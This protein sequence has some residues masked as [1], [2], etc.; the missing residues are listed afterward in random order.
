MTVISIHQVNS[1]QQLRGQPFDPD[2]TT[3]A[4]ARW[5]HSAPFDVKHRYICTDRRKPGTGVWP[6]KDPRFEAWLSTIGS[7]LLL[8]KQP[9]YNSQFLFSFL[10]DNVRGKWKNSCDVRCPT[11]SLIAFNNL[12]RSMVIDAI[13][14]QIAAD[15]AFTYFYVDCSEAKTRQ[16][17]YILRSLLAQFISHEPEIIQAEFRDLM[18]E[19]QKRVAF[20]CFGAF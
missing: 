15:H 20:R 4:M 9:R 17:K 3:A 14:L 11:Y 1:H 2:H 8:R 10:Y 19:R 6:L 16:P 5:L 18:H 7:L 12:S 13:Q